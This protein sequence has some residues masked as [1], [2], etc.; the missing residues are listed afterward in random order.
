[1]AKYNVGTQVAGLCVRGVDEVVI[2]LVF[3]YRF[4]KITNKFDHLLH[5]NCLF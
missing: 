2:C 4:H 5:L 1:M 3:N